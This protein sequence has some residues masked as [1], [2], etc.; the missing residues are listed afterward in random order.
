MAKIGRVRKG[1]DVMY[2]RF[3]SFINEGKTANAAYVEAGYKGVPGSNATRILNRPEVQALIKAHREEMCVKT[4]IKKE[5]ILNDLMALKNKHKDSKN[6]AIA[7]KAIEQISR[8]LGFYE[9]DKSEHKH[10]WEVG[11]GDEQDSQ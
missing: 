8:L 11:F 2:A 7:I 6:P 1:N 9:P 3:A 5:D 4:G 10:E